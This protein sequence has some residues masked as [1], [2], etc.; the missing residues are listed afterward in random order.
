MAEK[1]KGFDLAAALGP[2]PNL[3]T[4]T[5]DRE[6]LKY[7]PLGL[8]HPDPDNFYR[9]DGLEEL[10]GNIELIGLQQPLRV[11]PDPEHEGEYIVVS[12]H[13]RRAAIELLVNEGKAAFGQVPCLIDGHQESEA[14]RKLRLIFAN[15][16]TRR[17]TSA[18]LSQ[19]A[20]DVE[21]L[22]YQLQA[23]GTEFPGRMR[24]HVADVCQ[25]T[26]SKLARLKVIRE[27]LIEPLKAEWEKGDLTESSAY[28]AAQLPAERQREVMDYLSK[29]KWHSEPKDWT[30]YSVRDAVKIIEAESKLTNCVKLR[31]EICTHHE[32]RLTRRAGNEYGYSDHCYNGKC[33]KGC[34]SLTT[35]KNVCDRCAVEASEAKAKLKAQK[36]EERAKTKSENEKKREAI[37]AFWERFRE[38]RGVHRVS[39]K[40]AVSTLL[41]REI[42]SSMV[43]RYE[44]FESGKVSPDTSVLCHLSINQA[45]ELV[46]TADLLGVSLDYLF[47]RTDDPG[48][49]CASRSEQ[50]KVDDK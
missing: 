36:A 35:C 2:V 14:M 45:N 42:H 1:K 10:A 50:A 11:R 47:C 8:L 49:G 3:G 21:K 29:T 7:I 46:A 31:G 4:D 26:K 9:L 6:Q 41:G 48:G 32:G 22:L 39:V 34:P 37:A 15:S 19:Q 16:S 44:E 5:H 27:K 43:D 17:L 25:T 33:C 28:A 13:R 18:E 30:E 23:E 40:K 38:A 20:V 24:D 12:G